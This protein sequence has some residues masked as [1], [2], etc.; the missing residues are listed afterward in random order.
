VVAELLEIP[1]LRALFERSG[2]PVELFREQPVDAIVDGKWLSGVMDR[3]HLHRDA[4]GTVTRVEVIDFK[5][6]ALDE[7]EKLVDRYSA[8]MNAYRDVM[9]RAYPNARI[10]CVLL[11]TRCRAWAAV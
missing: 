1:A 7:L 4:A 10:E 11:S 6:D 5:T 2:R 9:A 3:L 8:Q